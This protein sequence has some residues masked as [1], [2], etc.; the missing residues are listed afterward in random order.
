MRVRIPDGTLS[1]VSRL[2][3]AC[4]ALL[5]L[6]APPAR[7]D[8]PAPQPVGGMRA[9]T[10][11]GPRDTL[12]DLAF[13]HRVGFEA[14]ERLNPDVEVWVPTPGTRVLL[15][16][17]YVLPAAPREGLVVNLPEMRLYDY[18]DGPMPRVYALAIGDLADPTPTG[19]FRV[20]ARRSDP[21]W[22]VPPSI[23]MERPEIG[24][25]VAPGPDNPLGSRWITIGSTY[26]GLHGTNLPWSIGR[27]TTHGCLRLYDDQMQELYARVPADAPLRIVYQSVKLGETREG[28]VIEVHPDVYAREPARVR[29]LWMRL[30]GLG[31]SDRVDWRRVQKAVEQPLGIPVPIE[32]RSGR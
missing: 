16:S 23:R 32:A 18:T 1:D 30:R 29:A 7:A 25:T 19:E 21:I 9:F 5:W 31:L 3:V 28:L 22:Y 4:V 8:P 2:H 6:G 27:M 26:Y 20:G 24:P 10:V 15:P 14:L 17:R 11:V 12:V 13:R